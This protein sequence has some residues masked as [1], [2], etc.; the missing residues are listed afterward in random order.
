[1]EN[2]RAESFYEWWIKFSKLI[3]EFSKSA[4]GPGD[5]CDNS[6]FQRLNEINSNIKN[7]L[8]SGLDDVTKDKLNQASNDLNSAIQGGDRDAINQ[9]WEKF[10][11]AREEAINTLSPEAKENYERAYNEGTTE[12]RTLMGMNDSPKS[13]IETP[14]AKSTLDNDLSQSQKDTPNEDME[15]K[16]DAPDSQQSNDNSPSTPRPR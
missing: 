5:S 13:S 6:T 7:A 1:M 10:S 4:Q 16:N 11:Q 3:E 9:A 8:Y 2:E 15:N 14:E 12:A